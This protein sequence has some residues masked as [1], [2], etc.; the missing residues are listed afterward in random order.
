VGEVVH[1]D[2]R[3]E[4]IFNDFIFDESKHDEVVVEITD[5]ESGDIYFYYEE[6]MILAATETESFKELSDMITHDM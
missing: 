5:V 4:M 6:D 3:N 1:I 2:F